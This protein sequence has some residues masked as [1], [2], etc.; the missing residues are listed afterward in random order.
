[1]TLANSILAG[2]TATH[3]VVVDKS[4]TVTLS[5]HNL[6]GSSTPVNAGVI[7]G[8]PLTGIANLG[9]LAANGGPGMETMLPGAGSGALGTGDPATALAVDER[10]VARLACDPVDLGAVQVTPTPACP[11]K[12]GSGGSG[13][14]G[15]NGGTG[16]SGAASLTSVKFGDQQIMLATPSLQACTAGSKA[17][18]VALA[19]VAIRGSHAAK[20][21]FSR[22]AFYIGRGVKHTTKRIKHLPGGK[23]E[24]ITV[25]TYAPNVI[26][27]HVPADVGLELTGLKSGMHTLKVVMSYTETV[28]KHGHKKTETITKT[29][30]TRFQIC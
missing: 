29:L 13:G 7:V 8:T 6:L 17:L 20:L 14:T 24:K 16:G 21:K 2:S 1:M 30:T 11:T 27:R 5:D 26:V 15:G 3:D 9:A 28:T 23:T 22:A 19:S 18:R 10:G 12:G 25:T 4:S